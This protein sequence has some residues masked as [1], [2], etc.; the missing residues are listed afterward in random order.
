MKSVHEEE[1]K[2]GCS[3]MA[4]EKV[5]KKE[6][7]GGEEMTREMGDWRAG[8]RRDLGDLGIDLGINFQTI[9]QIVCLSR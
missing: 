9:K 5:E 7:E 3:E 8:A 2:K 6:E 1:D 4:K